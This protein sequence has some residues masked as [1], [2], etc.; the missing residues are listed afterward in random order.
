MKRG[1]LLIYLLGV[2]FT[3]FAC[4][5]SVAAPQPP[6][7]GPMVVDF[8]GAPLDTPV[9][10]LDQ[11][12]DGFRA[13]SG[14][15]AD[16]LGTKNIVVLRVYFKDYA[17]TSRYTKA[18]V[19][20]FFNTN[21]NT[22]WQHSSYGK[23][24][25]NA[26]VTDLYQLPQ[27]RSNYITDH[28]DGDTSDGNQYGNVLN[29]AIANSPAGLD[30]TNV[31]AVVVI[32][33]ETDA[34]Q[35][36]RGQGNKANLPMGPG[37]ATKN[38]GAAI[39][40]ENPSDV[41]AAVWGRW[42]H[43]MGHAFQQGGPAHPSN[44][45]SSFEQMDANYPGQTG[46]FEKQSTIAFP[47]WLPTTKYINMSSAAGGSVVSIWAEEYDPN[48]KPNAQALKISLSATSYYLVSVRRRLLGDDLNPGFSPAGIPDEGVLIEKV[49]EGA[50]QWVTI[51]GNAGDR[52]KL[53]HDGDQYSNQ[54]EG[55]YI[56]IHKQ[57]DDDYSISVDFNENSNKPEVIINPWLSPPGNTYESTDIWVDSPVNGYGTFR[58]GT[59][60]D[61]AGGT[62]PVG[63]GD[64]PAIGQV[65]R[66]Y[67]RV[68]NVG[69]S[70]ANNVVVHI[71]RTDPPGL[72]MNGASGWVPINGTDAASTI[73]STQ[74]AAL[75]SISAGSSTDVY[76]NWTPNFAI[77]P[78]QQA[79]GVFGFHTC[80]RV[81]IDPV[82]NA[83]SNTSAS[84]DRQQEN[85]DYFQA[86]PAGP[87]AS[88]TPVHLRNDDKVNP[89]WFYLAYDSQ[90]PPAWGLDVNGGMMQVL[91][92]PNE[93]RD[94]PVTIT[95]LGPAVVGSSFGV[96]V[97]ASW[98]KT[99]VSD[100]NPLNT[101]V[102]SKPLSGARVETHV[103][104]PTSITC[105]AVQQGPRNI[106]VTGTLSGIG[107]YYNAA[108]PPKVMIEALNVARG[109]QTQTASV[110]TV[111]PDGTFTGSL[112][113]DV[114]VWCPFEVVCM[115]AGTNTLAS[116][117][118][119]DSISAV[120][121][122]LPG[123]VTGDC[124]LGM[125]DVVEM[126]RI[127]G[128]LETA[129]PGQVAAADTNGN[130]VIDIAD[131]TYWLQRMRVRR[132]GYVIRNAGNHYNGYGV[133]ID[134]PILNGHPEVHILA[135]HRFIGAYNG[136]IG[137]WYDPNYLGGRWLVYNEDVSNM[138]DGEVFNYYLGELVKTVVRS[139]ATT[140]APWRVTLDDPAFNGAYPLPLAIHDYVAIDDYMP[141]G[142]WRNANTGNWE[143]Y[144]EDGSSMSNGERYF[145]A[146][147]W[148]V[149]GG[150]VTHFPSNA[151]STYG[152]YI[153]DARVNGNPNAILLAQHQ[154]I[155]TNNV[156]PVGVWYDYY[157]GKW[158]IY[159]ENF[160]ALPATNYEQFN[161]L[162]AQP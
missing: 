69:H 112:F 145:F 70:A 124:M 140:T 9:A 21:L 125:D 63:N 83:L 162:I 114:S 37:G 55:I 109:F 26:R 64:D 17:N 90:L 86:V 13:R 61:L 54:P 160:Y 94:I 154:Q 40:S 76:L 82:S 2:A 31:D 24:N 126:L 91:L 88:L 46:V 67:V 51:V 41:D 10:G 142:V 12:R 56:G 34:T 104:S 148:Q 48:G 62:V 115:F 25:I 159:N 136:P 137:V 157:A 22:L 1:S 81:R 60:S 38:V 50:S 66:V 149:G 93:V 85:I 146:D 53:W 129:F 141:L 121:P 72:G 101:H 108:D 87:G 97:S 14:P 152:V 128:G 30:W 103:M 16:V 73:D 133:Y 117:W 143:A 47:G 119:V 3:G 135:C 79:A 45:N 151:Y 150:A 120:S 78:Q 106:V 20:G 92:Q 57:T 110:L 5:E 15:K 74:F 111:N 89:K 11:Y 96:N 153:D 132:S 49:V 98:Y 130:G 28:P 107:P 36:H 58:Y 7:L 43:E 122:P 33:A 102:E 116:C 52:D 118:H 71:D 68:R 147:A 123:D 113:S 6:T 59:W 65:N 44:Y 84:G 95:P 29:D 23:M 35:F 161:Y 19:D 80:L 42:S 39:F 156:S 138:A 75:A 134:D 144:N 100:K 18:Q 32:M 99:L 27:N 155:S 131:A 139:P 127:V 8:G 105:T 77:T 4:R 158:V